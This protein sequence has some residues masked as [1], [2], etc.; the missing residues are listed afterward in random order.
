MNAYAFNLRT[1]V[2][3]SL[4]NNLIQI[5]TTLGLGF[6]LDNERLGTRRKRAMIGITIDAVWITGEDAVDRCILILADQDKR[7]RDIR[8]SNHLAGVLEIRSINRRPNDRL[9]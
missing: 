9:Y 6:L 3:N 1:R 5:P 7:C 2:L 8:C 4:L